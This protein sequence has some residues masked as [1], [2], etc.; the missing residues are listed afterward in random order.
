MRHPLSLPYQVAS[1]AVF[2]DTAHYDYKSFCRNVLVNIE[3]RYG[4][5]SFDAFTV[6]ELLRWIPDQHG[7]LQPLA[8]S[9]AGAV[10]KLFGMSVLR[11]AHFTCFWGGM[12]DVARKKWSATSPW[13][14][15]GSLGP[16]RAGMP[17]DEAC[18]PAPHV[19]AAWL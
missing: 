12:S 7:Y 19:V 13:D 11:V 9:Q 17:A 3:L 6:S 18:W 4:E 8:L 15:L 10:R 5:G 16:L 2:G 14:L 1:K